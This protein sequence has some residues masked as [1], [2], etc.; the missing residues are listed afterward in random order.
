MQTDCSAVVLEEHAS[1]SF[2]QTPAPS[3]FTLP[4]TVSPE[5]EAYALR[6]FF[7][8]HTIPKT[9]ASA[10]GGYLSLLEDFCRNAARRSYLHDALHAIA[11]VSINHLTDSTWPLVKACAYRA[12]ALTALRQVLSDEVEAKSDEALASFFLLERLEASNLLLHVNGNTF[13]RV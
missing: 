2:D 1:E 8:F 7:Y 13:L 9:P 11:L 3:N 6:Y 5:W 10:H 4:P 12:R